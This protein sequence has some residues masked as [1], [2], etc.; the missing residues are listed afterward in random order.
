MSTFD[1]VGGQLASVQAHE[2][3]SDAIL[4]I[5]CGFE[6]GTQ[7][8]KTI[9]WIYGSVTE[10]IVTGFVM[11]TRGWRSVYCMPKLPA[12]RGSAPINMT[13]R[14]GQ[15][16]RWATGSVEIFFSKWNP[17][18]MACGSRLKL[19]ER[20]AYSATALYPFTAIILTV[21]CFLPAFALF[22]N[23]FIVQNIDNWAVLYFLALFVC[24]FATALLEI[25]WGGINLEDWWRNEQFWV[26]GGVSA[27]LAAVIQVWKY[28]ERD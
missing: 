20:V 12:F 7:W 21:Y 13:D 14:L 5:S 26:I 16:L 15:V 23:Q 8:G 3:L 24:I 4:V 25:R 19:V 2:V 10:D 18:W 28:Y 22:T 27:H 11:H 1:T 6:D 17:I 9:G